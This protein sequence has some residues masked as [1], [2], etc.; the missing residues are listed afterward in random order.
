MEV[1]TEWPIHLF[2]AMVEK[3]ATLLLAVGYSILNSGDLI[4][5]S[6][7]LCS[8]IIV[9]CFGPVKVRETPAAAAILG[10]SVKELLSCSGYSFLL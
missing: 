10:P 5:T 8:V 4:A 2:P 6:Y 9:D 7:S 1:R 3:A